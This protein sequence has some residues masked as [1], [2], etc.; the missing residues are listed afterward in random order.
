MKGQEPHDYK[1]REKKD[2]IPLSSLSA[3]ESFL[4]PEVVA[5]V[6]PE[7]VARNKVFL[8]QIAE[9]K[10]LSEHLH[11]IQS[12]V[13]RPDLSL[14]NAV[15]LEQITEEQVAGLYESLAD[16][17]QNS[18]EYRRII[19]SLPFEF[20]PNIDWN[21]DSEKLREQIE[22]FRSAYLNAWENLLRIH[23]VRANFIDGDVLEVEMRDGDLPRV[24]KAAHLIPFLVEKRWITPEEVIS[25][26]EVNEDETLRKSIADGLPI[27]SDLGLLDEGSRSKMEMSADPLIQ[28]MTRIIFAP[29]TPKKEKKPRIINAVSFQ[30][31]LK[32]KFTQIDTEDLGTTTEKRKKWIQKTNKQKAVADAGNEIGLSI[33]HGLLPDEFVE[34]I[35]DISSLLPSQLA[36]IDGIRKAIEGAAKNNREQAKIW[37]ERFGNVLSTLWSTQNPEIQN[38]LR[39][40]FF[41]LY[42]LRV[43]DEQT[44]SFFEISMPKL[45]GPFLDNLKA[46]PTEMQ[47][48]QAMAKTIESHPELKKYVYPV[49]LVFGSRVKGYGTLDA[50]IDTGIFVRPGTPMVTRRNIQRWLGEV[51]VHEKVRGDI[52]EFWLEETKSGLA[53][54]DFDNPD[55]SL[56]DSSWTHILFGAVWEGNNEALQELYEHLLAP[57]FFDTKEEIYGRAARGLYLEEIERDTLQYRLM[58]KGYEAFFPSFG[59]IPTPHADWIDGSSMFWDSGYR[60][61]ATKLFVERVFLPKI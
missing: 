48:I 42:H 3:V 9:R 60:N 6:W 24:V 22:R 1:H 58:H 26:I 51:F 8:E 44:L 34:Q 15:F 43:I 28:N 49:I 31:D 52:V 33:Q 11:L 59:G 36:L 32:Q 19:L 2:C 14:E 38:Y 5:Q 46:M 25:M 55:V 53:V 7:W 37:Y 12:H 35:S 47:E 41:R 16:L 4:N 17:L 18:P 13:R 57:Y 30:T 40:L 50:D 27:L 10:K 23:D 21:P 39:K 20:L 54:R 61:L 29:R 45:G 56:G